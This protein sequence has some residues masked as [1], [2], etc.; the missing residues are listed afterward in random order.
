MDV[1][2]YSHIKFINMQQHI[3]LN[4]FLS[5]FSHKENNSSIW[6]NMYFYLYFIF[7]VLK[8]IYTEI[9][10]YFFSFFIIK[11]ILFHSLDLK[12]HGIFKKMILYFY[13]LGIERVDAQLFFFKF[14]VF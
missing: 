7:P 14:C 4:Y 6:V 8:Y 11:F 12:R 9:V 10:I 5:V 1:L 3:L 13:S 2:L